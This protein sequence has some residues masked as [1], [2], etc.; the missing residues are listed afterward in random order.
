MSVGIV[1]VQKMTSGSV[2]GIQIHDL[3]EKEGVSHSNPDI[4]WNFSALNY[5]VHPE[6]NQNFYKVAKERINQLN[7]PKAVRKDAIVMAQV[8]VTS[9]HE[10]FQNLPQEKM[11][12]FFEDSYKFLC[13]RY[14]KENVISAIVHLDEYTPHMHFNFVPV[15]T[16]GRLSAKSIL[17][18]QNLTQQHTAFY[19]QVG[20]HYGLNRGMT[21]EERIQK[22][23]NRKNMTVPEYKAYTAELQRVKQEVSEL[24]ETK[25]NT[26]EIVSKAQKE[27]QGIE[28]SLIALKAEYEAKKAYIDECDKASAVS[29]NIPDFAEVKQKGIFKKKEFITVPKEKWIEKHVSANEKTY[30]KKATKEFEV[31]I[32]EFRKTTTGQYIQQLEQ[33]NKAYQNENVLLQRENNT[34]KSKVTLAEKEMS[35]MFDKLKYVLSKLPPEIAQPFIEKWNTKAQNRSH[36]MER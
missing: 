26:L 17:T 16:D 9:D 22:G 12:Q 24:S 4:D 31:K 27:A 10:F 11:K 7:L 3:R 28:A 5:D 19:Q 23:N 30:L 15:T 25:Q 1:R 35:N 21:K 20:K 29:M 2:K 34:L 33:Q 36:G 32:S 13:N 6:N 18:R 14:G 8:L